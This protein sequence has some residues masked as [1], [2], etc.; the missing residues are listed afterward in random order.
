MKKKNIASTHNNVERR[1]FTFK[2]ITNRSD[3]GD[4]PEISGHAAVF[5]QLSLDLGFF[6]EKIARGAFSNTLDADVRALFNHDSNFVL[7]RTTNDT[8]KLNEDSIGLKMDIKP[9]NTSWAKDLMTS[10]E[11]G[12][13]DQASFGFRVLKQS[14]SE[15]TEQD[16][17]IR[18]VE[19]VELFDVSV[20]T[21]PAFPQTDVQLREIKK[22]YE[23]YFGYELNLLKKEN[24]GF[25]N[26]KR[27]LEIIERE[28]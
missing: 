28:V 5:D 16:E 15:D 10:I 9:P 23:D 12:D 13:I 17:L 21:F 2:F 22:N 7:G 11:R 3:D 4:M 25:K 19:E 8:L 6:K 26:L 20:V 24:K 27:R 14:W 1:D 18:T